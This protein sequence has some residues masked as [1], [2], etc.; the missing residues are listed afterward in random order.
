MDSS[1]IVIVTGANSGIGKATARALASTGARV[2]LACRS[3]VRGEAAL[4]E[5]SREAGSERVELMELDLASFESVRAFARRFADRYDRLS[6]LVNN[7]GVIVRERR[8]SADGYE[9]QFAVNH[10]GHFLLTAEL[11]P[12][13]AASAPA[14]VVTVSSGAHKIGR[15]EFSDINLDRRYT[16]FGAY[17]RSKLANVL[18]TRELSRR[19][20][21]TGVTANCVHPGGVATRFGIDRETGAGS[22][23]MRFV[24]L[25][26]AA[27][28]KG[29][30]TSVYLA[31]SPQVSNTSGE[32]FV[33]KL[34]RRP[35]RR[36]LDDALARRLWEESERIVSGDT[37]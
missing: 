13:L 31:T 37:R 15:I 3:T 20:A 23:I 14:R 21:G 10:L 11:F 32:Y 24:S 6:C 9:L 34:P 4:E 22:G 1:D 16:V 26:M 25:F 28:E 29:A 12:L 18:F 27:P 8:F 30:E 7:A 17:A 2:I 5:I 36:A 33:K 19:A 35:G